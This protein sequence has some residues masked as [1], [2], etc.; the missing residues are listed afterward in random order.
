MAYDPNAIQVTLT[1]EE[2]D[3]ITMA[4]NSHESTLLDALV[5]TDTN[6]HRRSDTY[7][8]LTLLASARESLQRQVRKSKQ[9]PAA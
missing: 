9:E 5:D 7:S 1:E 8:T 4:L 6:I 2:L 3:S